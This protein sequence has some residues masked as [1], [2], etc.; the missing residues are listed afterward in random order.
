MRQSC[1]ENLSTFFVFSNF[2]S[3]NRVFY[4]IMLKITVEPDRPNDGMAQAQGTQDYNY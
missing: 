2:F 1:R 3:E 4:E